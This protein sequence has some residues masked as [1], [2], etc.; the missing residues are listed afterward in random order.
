MSY[1]P[2]RYGEN[3]KLVDDGADLEQGRRPNIEENVNVIYGGGSPILGYLCH[4]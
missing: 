1:F 2:W 4:V 3:T